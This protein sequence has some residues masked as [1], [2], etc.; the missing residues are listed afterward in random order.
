[1]VALQSPPGTIQI[2]PPV[3]HFLENV[4][5]YLT[6]CVHGARVVRILP[7]T[8][9]GTRQAVHM[10]TYESPRSCSALSIVICHSLS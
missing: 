4:F 9:T 7:P 10:Q 8:H 5:K 1:M 6:W 3:D 2:P